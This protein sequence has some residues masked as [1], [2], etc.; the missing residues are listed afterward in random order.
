MKFL[1]E[2]QVKKGGTETNDVGGGS[3]DMFNYSK[4]LE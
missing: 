2:M 1:K 3:G 4:D